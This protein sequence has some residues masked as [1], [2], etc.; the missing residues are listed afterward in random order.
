VVRRLAWH[1]PH[2]EHRRPVV[3]AGIIMGEIETSD[4]VTLRYIEAGAGPPLVMVPGWSQTAAQF[5]H[6]IDG[7]SDRYRVIALDMRG[8]GDSDKP[9]HGYRIS[10]FAKDLRDALTALD[11]TEVNLLSHSLG[12]A[13]VWC[14][15]DMFGPARVAKLIL[16]DQPPFLTENPSWSKFERDAA[17]FALTPAQRRDPI[18]LYE[19]DNLIDAVTNLAGPNGEDVTRQ[20]VGSLFT[21][22]VSDEERAWAIERMLLLPRA[23]AARLLYDNA[24]QSWFDVVTRITQPTLLI[25]G[26]A[27]QIPWKSMLWMH[28]HIP[29]SRLEIFEEEDG[30]KHFTFMENPERFNRLVADFIG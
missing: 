17:E 24:L 23:Y 11:L 7:L 16:V 21:K 28:E 22:R 25:G 3:D 1:L 20:F 30:G 14:Y 12:C 8:H 15:L 29:G 4:G 2:R 18:S 26:K 6:Q 5:K 19:I 10:R 9:A 27:S 13:V